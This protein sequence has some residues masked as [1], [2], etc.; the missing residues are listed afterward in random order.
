MRV[1]ISID[2]HPEYHDRFRHLRGAIVRE[3]GTVLPEVPTLSYGYAL[4]NIREATLAQLVARYFERGYDQ[5]D[6]L[7]RAAH[8]WTL[9]V[10]GYHQLAAGRTGEIAAAR[11][12]GS[13]GVGGL[14]RG[15]ARDAAGWG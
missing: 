4:G 2:G 14:H 11:S 12:P 5:F 9:T 15:L 6:K 7:C 8:L 3:D 10:F 1:N 13:G